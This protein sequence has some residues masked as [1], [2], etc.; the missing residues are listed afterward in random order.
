[1]AGIDDTRPDLKAAA[2][3]V[4]LTLLGLWSERIVQSFWPLFTVVTA[5]LAVVLFGLDRWLPLEAWWLLTLG[6]IAATG[7][8]LWL[9]ARSFKRPTLIEARDRVDLRLPGRPLAAINDAMAL[10]QADEASR[11]M[12]EAHQRRMAERAAKAERVPPD[13]RVSRRDPYALRHLAVLALVAGLIFGGAFRLSQGGP[14]VDG[15]A[16]TD[17]G[18]TWEGWIDPPSYTGKPGLYLADIDSDEVGIP[19]GSRITLRLYGDTPP[20]VSQ[21]VADTALDPAE[22]ALEFIVTKSG[23]LSIG[24][25]DWEIT[26]TPDLAPEIAPDGDA[27][28]AADGEM[29]LKFTAND[30][31]GVVTATATMVL[32]LSQVTRR[33]GL[34]LDPETSEAIIVDLPMPIAGDRKVVAGTMS[35]NFSKHPWAGQPVTLT[36]MATDAA[37]QDGQAE[38]VTV[39]LEGK[40]FFDPLATAIAE[41]RRDLIWNRLNGPR[42]AQVLRASS[43]RPD[44]LNLRAGIYLRLKS[45]IRN[46]EAGMAAGPLSDT[47]RD[48]VAEQLWQIAQ[49][50]EDGKMADALER[51]R[52]AQEKLAEAIKNGASEEEIAELTQEMREAMRDYIQQLAQ[53]A[54]P[55]DQ[56]QQ[57]QNTQTITQDQLNEMM[58]KLQELMEQGRDEEAQ[59]LLDQL[60]QM[61]E[62]MQVTQSQG[63]GEG[64]QAMQGLSDTLKEQQ[65][66]SDDTFQDRQNSQGGQNSQNQPGG[67]G[68]Q[69]QQQGDQGQNGEESGNGGTQPDGTQG[70]GPNGES[71]A[72]RQQAL[73]DMLNDQA[74][75]LPGMSGEAGESMRRSLEDAG[76]AMDRAEDSL[77]DGD[78]AGALNDQ[79]D[80]M[81][82]LRQGMR[83]HGEM[84]AEQNS[85]EGRQGEARSEGDQQSDR[86]PLGREMGTTGRRIGTDEGLLQGDDVYR[87]AR[88]LLDEIRR[89]SS[90]RERPQIE[91][92]YLQRLL[93]Q[94]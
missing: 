37:G 7:L 5:A 32:D 89:R 35:E 17:P 12:W 61:M 51:L 23:T 82:N 60:M 20:N 55:G 81:E 36:L 42:V 58:N 38:S 16:A 74:Q 57:S 52:K 39:I 67:Q 44:E 41:Q 53:N 68:Q 6:G 26:A 1:M 48:D 72:D 46:L 94:F 50:I 9:G 76:R 15:I 10:G 69:E 63:G 49:D 64:D 19:I 87:R 75:R 27:E 34:V 73:R 56:Q 8:T 62:N 80:A 18:P 88:E 21:T 65:E 2:R 31:Y 54:E 79:A 85:G 66:L 40:R 77:R 43:W 59:A 84:L 47:L 91:L 83:D 92:D 30:D 78:Y 71:L 29:R 13:L 33:Y 3:A 45:V 22:K 4:R 28:R 24:D 70:S 93:D 11:Q 86:D 14:L 25:R 90:E